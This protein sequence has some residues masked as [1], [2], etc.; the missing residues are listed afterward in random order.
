MT[1]QAEIRLYKDAK[2]FADTYPFIPYQYSMLQDLLTSLRNKSASGKNLSN[3]ARS[4]LRIFKDTAASASEMETD[5]ITPLYAFYDAIQPELDSPTN[6]VFH[7]VAECSCLDEFDINVLKTLFLVKYYDR[8]D[9]TLA[10]ISALMVSSFDDQRQ[11]L[12]IKVEESLNKLVRENFVQVY[13]DSYMFLSNDEQ[14]ISREIR[15]ELV[16]QGAIYKDISNVAFGTIFNLS[17]GKLK[18]RQFNKYVED[19]N[20]MHTDYELSVRIL[21]TD[22][23]TDPYLPQ[24]S[25]DSIL[26]KIPD[27]RKVVDAFADYLRTENYIRKKEGTQQAPGIKSIL[28]GKRNEIKSMRDYA[29]SLLDT[30]LK[31]SRIFIN[32]EE[33]TISD[34]LSPE[35][36]LNDAVEKLV[37]SVYNKHEYV[38][39]TKSSLEINKFLEEKVSDAYESVISG[40]QNA[41]GDLIG[42][43]ELQGALNGNV[44]V[45]D[46]MDRYKKKPYGFETEDVQWMLAVLLKYGRIDLTFEGKRYSGAGCSY[47]DAKNCILTSK[48]YD[49]VRVNL[50]QAITQDQIIRASDIVSVLFAKTSMKTEDSVIRECNA[51]ASARL[52]DIDSCLEIYRDHPR[53]PG[54][55]VLKNAREIFEKLSKSKSPELFSFIDEN[56]E[57]LRNLNNEIQGI[58]DFL[59]PDSYSR[60]LFDR[61]VSTLNRCNGIGAYLDQ[62]TKVNIG[63]ISDILDSG[64][65]LDLPKLNNLCSDVNE[66]VDAATEKVRI[67]EL[68]NLKDVVDRDGYIFEAY[69]EL[70]EQFR[71]ELARVSD[72]IQSGSSIPQIMTARGSISMIIGSLKAKIPKSSEPDHGPV[73]PPV[74]PPA[75]KT[76]KIMIRTIAPTEVK[77]IGSEQDIESVLDGM[78]E[79]M[80]E[81]LA[82][83]PF[84]IIW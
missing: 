19:E 63:K 4:M 10:N 82:N 76:A 25:A 55:D 58:Y 21:V 52:A 40:M 44:V 31:N 84:D 77:T 66:A 11:S 38:N 83:G 42:Y 14:E 57:K 26:F 65:L 5:Y 45:K 17:S 9:K 18:G 22:R 41:F 70:Y 54:R 34:S 23:V 24:A 71:N 49:K 13:A 1:N 50:R 15:N 72:E 35:K 79:K 53:Y 68:D 16:D 3:A 62:D 32:K 27:G 7:R 29:R 61:G 33:S 69:P 75:P 39:R 60:K 78:R 67:D 8:L 12:R 51:G 30:A 37:A 46:I 28:E 48:N 64:V 74:E 36:R 6:I 81:K 56:E 20:I 59:Q 2:E 80:K 43:L 47:K 73:A